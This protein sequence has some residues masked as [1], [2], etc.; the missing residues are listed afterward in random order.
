V[1]GGNVT[2]GAREFIPHL[3]RAMVAAGCDGLFMEVHDNVD[4]ARS[5][6][7]TQ[8]PLDKLP[9]LIKQL[10]ELGGLVR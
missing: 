6:R 1:P 3:S 10:M 5:D 4:Q 9:E 7:A 2:G 8:Y